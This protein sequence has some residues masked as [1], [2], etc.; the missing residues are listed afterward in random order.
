[1]VVALV[2]AIKTKQSFLTQLTLYLATLGATL[3][4]FLDV[5]KR[6]AVPVQKRE[7][8]QFRPRGQVTTR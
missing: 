3:P 6:D 4:P 1:M 2:A 5:G 7:A 8:Q